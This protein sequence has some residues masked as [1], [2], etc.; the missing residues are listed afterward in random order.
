MTKLTKNPIGIKGLQILL[1]DA[2]G[3]RIKGGV[4]DKE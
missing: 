3:K 2:F 1:N 4:F